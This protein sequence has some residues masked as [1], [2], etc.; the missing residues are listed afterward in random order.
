MPQHYARIAFTD[1]VKEAQQANGS[2]RAMQ[3]FEEADFDNDVLGPAEERFITERDGFYL[4]TTNS[5]GWPYVQYRGGPPG[6]VHVIDE[7]TLAWA[8]L[9]GNRQYISHG[10]LATDQRA[11]VFL[12]D[13]ARQRRLKIFGSLQ[14]LDPDQHPELRARTMPST[15]PAQIQRLARLHVH[16]H[17]WNCPQHITPRYTAAELHEALTPMREQ[18]Q[19]LRSENDTLRSELARRPT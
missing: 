7:T 14:L 19:R 9:R 15:P 2:R 16:A 17:D 3:R 4:A 11:S 1:Q 5:S 12:M 8:E 18:L 6:F 10:N 13:Y